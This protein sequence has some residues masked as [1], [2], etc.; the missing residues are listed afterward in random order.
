M[1][2]LFRKTALGSFILLA[3]IAACTG[4][5]K[6]ETRSKGPAS[7][8]PPITDRP[9]IIAYGDSLIAGYGIE[10]WEDSFS[11]K[12]QK[13]IDAGRY[14]YQVLN[15]GVNGDTFETGYSRLSLNSSL[16]NQR[17]FI[18][19]LG[20]NNISR[21][22]DPRHITE[23][24]RDIILEIRLRKVDI[25]LCGYR[26]PPAHGDDYAKAIDDMYVRLASEFSLEFMPD[27]M[28][29]VTHDPELMQPDG[30]HPNP[31]GV[32][33]IVKNVF[34]HLKPILDKNESSKP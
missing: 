27:F 26:S 23:Y 4:D 20:A 32:D 24:L 5:Q 29:G 6:P 7:T 16:K 17:I 2:Y 14:N 18:L 33:R 11:A 9:K 8:P 3:S 28:A 21:K 1:N 31:K 25:L 15:N 13:E 10:G 34:S 19:E 12:L 30:I 22:D